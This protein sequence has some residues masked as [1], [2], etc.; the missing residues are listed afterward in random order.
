MIHVSHSYKF[1]KASVQ[2]VVFVSVIWL[3]TILQASDCGYLNFASPGAESL[4]IQHS[5]NPHC[6]TSQIR[7]QAPLPHSV[8]KKALSGSIHSQVKRLS[9]FHWFL[10]APTLIGS[11]GTRHSEGTLILSPSFWSDA[12]VCGEIVFYPSPVKNIYMVPSLTDGL[13]KKVSIYVFRLPLTAMLCLTPSGVFGW[14]KVH[15]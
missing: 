8:D 14:K 13:K 1:I 9:S 11:D 3:F 5:F 12:D 10:S 15:E 6:P 7:W 4:R 2:S